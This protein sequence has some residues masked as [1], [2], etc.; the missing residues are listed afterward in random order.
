M[1]VAQPIATDP[2]N[3]PDHSVMHRIIAC[4]V[5][6]T[7]KIFQIDSADNVC[8]G[9]ADLANY[10]KIA[11]GGVMSIV[12][13]ANIPGF[14]HHMGIE[15]IG[16]VTF[17]DDTHILSVATITYWFNGVEY[18]TTDPTTCDIDDYV[19]IA[20]NTVYLFYFDASAGLLKCQAGITANFFTQVPVAAVF[21]NGTNGAIQKEWHSSTRDLDWHTWAH[22][23]VGTRYET[24]LNS[25][26]PTTADDN[27]LSIAGG[28]IMD[29][30]LELVISNPQTTCRVLYQVSSGVYTWVNSAL[31]YAGS[32]TQPQYL[33]T[34]TWALTNVGASDF[35][36]MWVY[37]TSDA[38][39]P[40][41][42]IPTHATEAHN[43]IALA[44][45]ETQPN[46]ATLNLSPE[47]KLLWRYI[48]KGDGNFQEKAD[49][50]TVTSLPGGGVTSI[51]ASAVTFVP[52]GTIVA[53]D[54]QNALVELDTEKLALAG[55]TL[56]GNLLF[57]DNTLDIGASGATR[58]RTLYLG[59]SIVTP[60]I[61]ATAA[62]LTIKP[63][64]DAVTAIQFQDKDGNS[65]LN[66]DT[67]NNRVGI[68]TVTPL[69]P[70]H[71]QLDQNAATFCVLKN[72]TSGTAAYAGFYAVNAA[73]IGILQRVF[74]AGFTT[75]GLDIASSGQIY[76]DAG[77]TGG[78]VLYHAGNYPIIFGT[79]STERL[80]I[81][82]DGSYTFGSGNV[83]GVGTFDCGAI[84]SSGLMTV[85]NGAVFNEASDDVDFRIES[86]GN[87]NMFFIDGGAD[88]VTIGYNGN[89]GA[90]LNVYNAT[91][92]T[93][94]FTGNHLNIRG[95]GGATNSISEISFGIGGYTN[96]VCVVG[97]KVID[98]TG[99]TKSNFY[100]GLRNVT[101]DTAPTEVF[102]IDT[103]G[104]TNCLFGLNVAGTA[105]FNNAVSGITTLG[106]G[107]ITSSGLLIVNNAIQANR[108]WTDA[109][110][111]G[112]E[113]TQISS[114]TDN[115]TKYIKGFAINQNTISITS[116][117]TNS[118][119]VYGGHIS[120]M[121]TAAS[122]E[123]TLAELTGLNLDFGIYA[124]VGTITNAYGLKI[125]PYAQ[126]GTITNLYGLY[127]G[128]VVTG[129]TVTN[130]YAIYSANTALSYF[131]GSL[132]T[133][134]GFGCNSKTAQTAYAS[135][136]ALSGYVTGAFG[137][138]SAAHAQEIHTLLVNIRAALVANGIMS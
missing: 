45:T 13:T 84:T 64:T 134:L 91:S 7:A 71:I 46:L 120:I 125:T 66:I 104:L 81:L 37:G 96:K 53:A 121:S 76:C 62:A 87:A 135:G 34:D 137:Y 97:S 138:D 52:V 110:G 90:T 126:T 48:Y 24:G 115:L 41:Y 89:L 124:G 58:P 85:N 57:T 16:A 23:T 51:G 35:A 33:D 73:E 72:D 136:G 114:I 25:T 17:A 101:T 28:T 14:K 102:R 107:A 75:S 103:T 117:K 127:L 122:F 130:Q 128:A 123:G 19:V 56:T 6:A 92:N 88:C 118:G 32:G 82:G 50:R 74:S 47:M 68:G 1:A 65:I 98:G 109:T 31:P 131:A 22:D 27:H 20:N 100:I 112:I 105:T 38:D 10:I 55:G 60:S 18:T 5:A 49:Y 113:L 119:Y 40:I 95:G 80:R 26:L 108:T 116:G 29:E 59:T 129:G 77:L 78:M 94:Q 63:T 44:R 54:V 132:Q 83:S 2:L 8:I 3:N 69:Y 39:R 42:I 79:N 86:N 99:S 15:A 11:S 43:T 4:D 61:I 111:V 12:G 67:T 133:N 106:C 21:W 30:D 93:T 36:C 70:L 9:D